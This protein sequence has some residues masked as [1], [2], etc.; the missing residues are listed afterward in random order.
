MSGIGGRPVAKKRKPFHRFCGGHVDRVRILHI[1]RKIMRETSNE[2]H[3]RIFF[4]EWQ[5]SHAKQVNG[6]KSG[7]E[8]RK[9]EK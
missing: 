4:F 1:S 5:R 8:K 2:S 3:V 6:K 9:V 7:K